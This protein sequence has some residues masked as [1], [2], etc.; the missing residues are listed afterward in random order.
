MKNICAGLLLA[1]LGGCA[2]HIEL[3]SDPRGAGLAASEIGEV[4]IEAQDPVW[5]A[6]VHA[7]FRAGEATELL[8]VSFF[9]NHYNAFKLTP[10]VYIFL[11]QCRGYEWTAYPKARLIVQQGA[12]YALT[13]RMNERS[14][15]VYVDARKLPL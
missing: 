9:G 11:L 13:C 8:N 12:R 3:Y 6:D 5:G 15:G 1:L 10:G 14:T 2:K 4:T 7:L